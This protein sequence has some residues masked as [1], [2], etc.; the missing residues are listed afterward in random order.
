MI[1][2]DVHT[3]FLCFL[4]NYLVAFKAILLYLMKKYIFL[5]PWPA[6]SIHF[7]LRKNTQD[8]RIGSLCCSAIDLSDSLFTARGDYALPTFF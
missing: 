6:P 4:F 5:S 2:P 3:Q 1:I 8:E 7:F